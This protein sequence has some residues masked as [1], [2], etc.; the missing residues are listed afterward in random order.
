VPGCVSVVHMTVTLSD[1]Q[2]KVWVNGMSDARVSYGLVALVSQGL[3]GASPEEILGIHPTAVAAALGLKGGMMQKAP[4]RQNGLANIVKTVQE[5]VKA[6]MEEAAAVAAPAI[7]GGIAATIAAANAQSSLII[8][9]S[10][11]TPSIPPAPSPLQIPLLTH[12]F[13]SDEVAVLFSGGVDSSVALHLLLQQGYK[14]R[15]FYLKIWL[16]DELAHLNQCPWEE[17][18]GYASAVCKQAGNIPL[19]A[20]PMQKEYWA[21]VVAHTIQEAK[22]GRTPNPDIL[23]NSLVKFGVFYEV[24]GKR[25]N[26]VATGHYARAVPSAGGGG[27]ERGREGGPMRLMRSPDRIKD[28]T[29][30]LSRL[31]QEQLARAT[32]PIGGYEKHEIRTMAEKL[33]LPT[34]S[35]KDSQGICFLGKEGGREGGLDD[36]GVIGLSK[37]DDFFFGI[38]PYILSDSLYNQQFS[39]SPSLSSSLPPPGKLRFDDFLRHYLGESPG[40]VV[41]LEQDLIVGKHN[42]LWFHT[43]GQRKGIVPVLANAYRP[44]GPWYVAAKDPSRNVLFVTNSPESL[45]LMGGAE[46][47][48]TEG[49]VGGGG[50][51]EEARRTFRVDGVTWISGAPPPALLLG[52]IMELEV[53]IRHGPN[54]HPRSR[55]RALAGMGGE[56]AS[57]LEVTLPKEDSLAPGQYAAFYQDAGEEGIECLGAGVISEETWRVPQAPYRLTVNKK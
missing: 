53:Q 48:G 12:N 6:R 49:E 4:G 52:Q 20:I 43:I 32:F 11:I 21:Q 54:S 10:S 5:E 19:E 9:P 16:E 44:L 35:R 31:K 18:W 7:D 51:S 13:A 30:F 25:F 14:P 47:G 36:C 39:L 38:F 57:C 24:M 17:D 28:Q 22:E 3:S 50:G 2:S 37:F 45:S 55:V 40:R 46:E 29:Y 26:K 56:A 34:K 15:A 33:D 23:C 1:D 41:W 8:D 27:G 42:G